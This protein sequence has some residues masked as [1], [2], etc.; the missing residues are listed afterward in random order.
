MAVSVVSNPPVSPFVLSASYPAVIEMSST[1]YGTAGI[2]QFRYVAEVTA[3]IDLGTKT[4]VPSVASSSTGYFDVHELFKL[5]LLLRPEQWLGASFDGDPLTQITTPL[6]QASYVQWTFQVVIKEQYYNSGVFTTNVGPTLTFEA[7][8][9]WTDLTDSEWNYTNYTEALGETK[10][11]PYSGFNIWQVYPIRS[12]DPN[13]PIVGSFPWCIIQAQANDTGTIMATWGFLRDTLGF[14]GAV[15][16][17]MFFIG[18]STDPGFLS[19]TYKV[20]VNTVNSA[21]GALLQ[22]S[23]KIERSFEH[24]EDENMIMFQDRFFQWSFMPFTK[25]KY[26]A[27]NT[28]PQRAEA[29]DGRFRY[30]VKSS[31]VLTLNTDWL[32]DLQNELMRDLLVSEQTFLV[33][34]DD[35]SLE[36]V[37]VIPNSMR[38][39][40]HDVDGLHQYTMQFRKSLDNF[41]P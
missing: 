1:I 12:K 19:V 17:P 24:C 27:I 3:L 41:K 30:N 22:D 37:T 20:H 5:L 8:R 2:T 39:R 29:I 18:Q 9:G 14:Q 7:A 21:A 16:V 32:D 13:W 10:I 11:L 34:N 40:T 38:L 28:E 35:G 15:Y 36:K 25:Y 23:Y 33:D 26:T 4:T 6:Q 31:D